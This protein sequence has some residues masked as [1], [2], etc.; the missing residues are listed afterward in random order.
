MERPKTMLMRI[1]IAA[2]LAVATA[3]FFCFVGTLPALF[4]KP[5]EGSQ[6]GEDFGLGM[7]FLL[8]LGAGVTVAI[9]VFIFSFACLSSS[10]RKSTT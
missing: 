1:L 6:L 4:H 3:V 5:V 9:W 10:S 8:G 2:A 7:Y